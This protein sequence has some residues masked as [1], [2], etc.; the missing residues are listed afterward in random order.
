MKIKYNLYQI[1]AFTKRPFTG[2][3]AGVITNADGLREEDMQKI[4]RELN[5]SETA[6]IFSSEDNDHDLYIRYFTPKME[7]PICGHATIA[8]HYARAIE[9]NLDTIQV[10]QKSGAGVLPVKIEKKENDY[11]IIMTQGKIDFGDYIEGVNKSSLLSALGLTEADLHEESR[12]QIV[13]TGHSK[14]M[15]GI[16]NQSKLDMLE[17][18]FSKLAILSKEI[19]CNGYYVFTLDSTEADILVKGRMFAPAVGINEDPVTGNANGPLGAYLIKHGM[20][21]HNGSHFKFKA[22]QGEAMGRA[23]VIAVEV[24]INNEQPTAVRISGDAVIVFKT[25]LIL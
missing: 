9:N 20:V 19:G 6:F 3:P 15:I 21:S 18:D 11:S 23:G 4:A 13:S 5:N 7:V 12:I 22:K 1:D 14:V 16:Q 10:M 2:N 24:E 17:P 8:A 25:E